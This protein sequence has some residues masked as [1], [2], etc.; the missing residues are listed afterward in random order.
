M[1][2]QTTTFIGRFN[3]DRPLEPHHAAYLRAFHQT[4]HCR[5]DLAAAEAP[6]DK[7]LRLAVGL[8][9]GPGGAYFASLDQGRAQ[10]DAPAGVIDINVEPGGQPSFNCLWAPTEDNAGI[11]WDGQEKFRGYVSWLAYIM[12]HF[13]QPW[14]YQLSGMVRW[15]GQAA[16]DK[17][18]IAVRNGVIVMMTSAR[19]VP[20]CAALDD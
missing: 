9:E 2:Y 1:G 15:Q 7:K 5:R 13:L 14:G 10:G 4:R 16:T 19:N 20:R 6:E 12:K 3:L 17:G 11:E 8:P 18:N